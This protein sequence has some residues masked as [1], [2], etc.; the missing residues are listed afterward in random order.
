[1]QY[2]FDGYAFDTG[3]RELRRGAELVSIAPQVFDL[4]EYLIR[5][6]DRVVTKDELIDAIWNGRAVSDAAVTTRLNVARSAIGD[7]GNEQGLIRTLPPRGFRFVAAV[8]EVEQHAAADEMAAS[9]RAL[10]DEPATIE[11][12]SDQD[13]AAGA[14]RA[15][16]KPASRLSI[17]VLPLTSIGG[18]PEQ[19]A[20]AAGVTENLITDLSRTGLTFIVARRKPHSHTGEAIDIRQ[21]GRDANARYVLEGSL[22]RSGDRLRVN[23]QLTHVETG[24]H[25]WADR[26]EKQVVDPFDLQDEIAWRLAPLV[27][28]QVVLNEARRAERLMFPGPGDL[29]VQGM[30]SLCDGLTPR[31]AV[32]ARGFFERALAIDNRYTVALAGLAN[33]D[34]NACFSLL[35]DDTAATLSR[36]EAN[37]VKALSLTPNNAH[38]HFVL[39]GVY[40]LTHRVD[41]AIAAY[42]TA[43]AL[44]HSRT[45]AL[46]C[47]GFAKCFIGRTA[48]AETHILEALRL[49]P[50]HVDAYY[51]K[52][53]MGEALIYLAED[54]RAADWL[55][56]SIETNRNLPRAHFALAAALGLLGIED[57]ATRAAQEGLSINPGFTI[58]RLQASNFS[59][60]PVYLTGL[61]RLI[62][63]LRLAGVPEG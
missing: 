39:G 58:R 31:S 17:L 49:C 21:A 28:T 3:T 16:G 12:E 11:G 19:A 59:N 33:V 29:I 48:E 6:R 41:Q 46:G 57:E 45:S 56:R 7:S 5:N 37:V 62:T 63:G 22:Q 52:Y 54:A 14:A 24:R 50:H 43:I 36:A 40:A 51:M 34:V 61:D 30:A 26:F 4:L 10:A 42:E 55:R 2:N 47:I 15:D 44:D 25:V 20:F 38:A 27:A 8:N 1:M 53:F 18:G 32:V 13:V 9:S 23:V 35:T 60:N